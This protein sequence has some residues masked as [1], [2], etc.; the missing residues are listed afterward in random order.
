MLDLWYLL[1]STVQSS[2]FNEVYM[3]FDPYKFQ[4]DIIS[5]RKI[6][7]LSRWNVTVKKIS[8]LSFS[9]CYSV[10][11]SLNPFSCAVAKCIHFWWDFIDFSPHLWFFFL[12]YQNNMQIRKWVI[13]PKE[14]EKQN[15]RVP[16]FLFYMFF[17][18]KI[19]KRYYNVITNFKIWV[20]CRNLMSSNR[21]WPPIAIYF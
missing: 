10:C 15:R 17:Q 4:N 21:L 18:P 9:S 13:K 5:G 8:G 11:L 16:V 3:K 20:N 6:F 19:S 7:F 12:P 2:N 14:F 1:W